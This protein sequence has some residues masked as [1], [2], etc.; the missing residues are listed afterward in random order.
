VYN[1]TAAVAVPLEALG[2]VVAKTPKEAA[3]GSDIILS[4]VSDDK[5]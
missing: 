2:A 1:R 4:C 5:V 3:Q